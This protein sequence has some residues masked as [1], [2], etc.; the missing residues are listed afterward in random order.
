MLD[1][2]WKKDRFKEATAQSLAIGTVLGAIS[3]ILLALNHQ[4]AGVTCGIIGVAFLVVGVYLG[5][6]GWDASD[7]Y[8][9][10]VVPAKLQLALGVAAL[11]GA[12]ATGF[13]VGHAGHAD[14]AS[15]GT[16]HTSTLG[17]SRQYAADMNS[18][19][20]H[21]TA[22]RVSAHSRMRAA[23]TPERQARAARSASDAFVHAAGTLRALRASQA[24]RR[25]QRDLLDAL[26]QTERAYAALA[27]AAQRSDATA[28]GQAKIRV[29]DGVH[30]IDAAF[31]QFARLGYDVPG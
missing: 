16:R 27:E 22:R 8:A 26:R 6:R 20:K 23:K 18:V 1:L 19:L 31:A 21:L 10:A 30:R 15:P 14:A 13:L 3:A 5:F 25:A 11:M 12:G 24:D 28:Y 2:K 7:T 4:T 9:I 17:P 29:R